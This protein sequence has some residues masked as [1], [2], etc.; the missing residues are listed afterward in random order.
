MI[1]AYPLKCIVCKDKSKSCKECGCT[2]CSGKDGENEQ[3]L[4]DECDNP[5]HISC[6]TPPLDAVPL[7]D[8]WF[9]NLTGLIM[10][11]I[12]YVIFCRYCPSCKVDEG[13][14]VKAGGKLKASK[15]KT[16]ASTS[17]SKRDWGKG[18][19]CVGRTKTCNKVPANHFGPI[20]GVE[21]GTTWLFRVQVS[22][23]Q[24]IVV[25]NYFPFL[26]LIILGIRSWYSPT[27][28]RRNTW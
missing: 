24:K 25:L 10:N 28:C 6:L 2:I 15:K 13:E 3:V 19:A 5:Y 18:M 17:T 16:P 27:S 4:C 7:D 14:I 23:E 26:F 9:V 1:G 22:C 12:Y 21:V 8:E 11:V 20:P